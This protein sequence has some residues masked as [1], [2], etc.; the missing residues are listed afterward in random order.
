[1]KKIIISLALI[2]LG[3]NFVSAYELLCLSEGQEVVTTTGQTIYTCGATI[4]QL[5]VNDDHFQT[6]P[7]NCQGLSCTYLDGNGSGGTGGGSGGG[8][9]IP[10]GIPNL[11]NFLFD[12]AYVVKDLSFVDNDIIKVLNDLVLDYE[13][14]VEADVLTTDFNDYAM[15][16]VNDN[17]FS[18]AKNIPVNAH[19]SMVVG[20]R[21]V[22]V[23]KIADYART[24]NPRRTARIRILHDI[25]KDIISPFNMYTTIVDY[26]RLPLIGERADGLRNLV[27]TDN[28]REYPIIGI[29]GID[30]QLNDGSISGNRLAYFGIT[31]SD[32]WTQDA[33]DMFSR[34][35]TWTL[36]GEDNDKDGFYD[37]VDCND[38]NKDIYP[39]APEIPYDG[40]DQD[41]NGLDLVDKDGDGFNFDVDCND[42]DP[43]INPNASEILN[44]NINQNCIND[45]PFIT[46][47]IPNLNWNEDTNKSIDL[48]PYFHDPDGD[49]LK[50][51]VNTVNID[52]TVSG[53]VITLIPDPNWFGSETVKFTASDKGFSVD[54]NSV[55]LTVIDTFDPDVI[56]PV[57]TLLLPVDGH[58][59]VVDEIN[60][61]FKVTDDKAN[62]LT[63]GFYTNAKT[64]VFELLEGEFQVNNGTEKLVNVFNI[65]D[66]SFE[67]NVKCD[68]GTNKAFAIKNRKFSV[69]EPDAPVIQNIN[70]ITVNENEKVVITVVASDADNDNLIYSINSAKFTQSNNVF[71]WMTNF[72]DQG[73]Y[74]FVVSVTDGIL[75]STKNVHVTVNN[76]N[77][78]PVFNG[79]IGDQAFEEDSN[80]NIDLSLYFSDPD[81]DKFSYSFELGDNVDVKFNND[82]A[83]IISDPN[84]NGQTQLRIVG[85]DGKVSIKSNIFNLFISP[86]NDAPVLNQ[87]LNI[88]ADEGDLVKI[89]ATA[90]DVDGDTLLFLY[91]FP[92]DVNGEWQTDFD[93]ART[94][95]V[96]VRVTDGFLFDNQMIKVFVEDVNIPP[97]L[98]HIDDFEI[99]EDSDNQEVWIL[100]G[101]D[102]DG[103]VVNFII[104]NEK[105][106]QVDCSI[107]QVDGPLFSLFL[108]PAKNFF[109]N[110]TCTVRVLDNKNGFSEQVVNIKVN[111][112]NDGPE[113]VS[114]I[115]AGNE[116]KINKDKSQTFIVVWNDVDNGG[117][118]V[119]WY[120][121]NVLKTSGDIFSFNPNGVVKDFNVKVVVKD[122]GFSD[123]HSWLVHSVDTVEP[124]VGD[125]QSCGQ[126]G[127]DICS[128]N[129]VC[130]G[131]LL[132]ANDSNI[133][134]SIQCV[135]KDE[136]PV[137]GGLDN[138]KELDRCSAGV[139]GNIE[140]DIEE[141]DESDEFGPEETMGIQITVQNDGDDDVDVK[142]HAILFDVS[143]DE[144]IEKVKSDKFDVNDDSD[145]E[146]ELELEIPGGE[147]D[148][149]D[150]FILFVKA[151][152][153]GNEDKQC[154]EDFID[155]DIERE[156]DD[157][158]IEDLSFSPSAITCDRDLNIKV[159]L[160]NVGTNEQD[161]YVQT[162]ILGTDLISTTETFTLEDFNDDD[163]DIVKNIKMNVPE[164]VKSGEYE[165]EVTVFYGSDS[166]S[167]SRNL[168]IN[169]CEDVEPVFI[170]TTK[171]FIDTDASLGAVFNKDR[172]EK[173]VIPVAI[174][175][176]AD[177]FVVYNLNLENSVI[178][179]KSKNI[180]LG[181]N[182]KKIVNLETTVDENA[183]SGKHMVKINVL[184]DGQIV[185]SKDV[186]LNVREPV[187][188]GLGLFGI[189]LI[190]L[191]VLALLIIIYFII[192]F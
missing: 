191:N 105:T 66:G 39:G 84:F 37:S 22:N 26:D 98:D 16:L 127:G 45:K 146:I 152:E 130:N 47:T 139:I 117:V 186:L 67:W 82:V 126:L 57:V 99:E 25:T 20:G 19:N 64:G 109:G 17:S 160:D 101:S 96:E 104:S 14:I 147:L 184:S 119:E 163:H 172:G 63:C 179:F 113:I 155:I 178:D 180:L 44:D 121:D 142:V 188:E 122:S 68:D 87:I 8:N 76:V 140:V 177:G 65:P 49:V 92:F 11:D 80:K 154:A 93:D 168:I 12:V 134:C 1:M 3:I 29:V 36:I 185:G 10:G 150:D 158:V 73:V 35:I 15:I 59:S 114:V 141:P 27:G 24:E 151:F 31:E 164:S 71:T 30:K 42:N 190:I 162:K 23:Y 81:N 53:S 167:E 72:N 56:A 110:A 161:V 182:E 83:T 159:G 46:G 133:C 51:T 111:G 94:Y 108:K 137:N 171:G 95:D 54:S 48:D 4:C 34:T 166:V 74:D 50:Y 7:V 112:L 75:T 85:S 135:L 60:F 144:E 123:E 143:N 38:N 89:N 189:S 145:E 70:N 79:V 62:V 128:S 125:G 169:G 175:N 13:V 88:F 43:N 69:D 100:R 58:F 170:P 174:E 97:V 183:R 106:N 187:K 103:S 61:K 138:L 136:P 165:L 2:L 131:S 149:D 32:F 181:K 124:P 102:P 86:V 173:L 9:E 18:N 129:E 55:V 157:V 41:C 40:I 90:S 192:I 77:R 78:N 176:Q 6:N 52:Y 148:E 5:C 118:T 156:E 107:E 153:S 28:S 115:P 33:E 132:D 120:V 91:E 21:Y 116:L